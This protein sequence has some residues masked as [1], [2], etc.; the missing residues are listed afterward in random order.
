LGHYHEYIEEIR[1]C[2]QPV[3]LL[4]FAKRLVLNV[5][6]KRTVGIEPQLVEVADGEPLIGFWTQVWLA[7]YIVSDRKAPTEVVS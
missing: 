1:Q 5:N 3:W 2:W 4:V 7:F 6:G